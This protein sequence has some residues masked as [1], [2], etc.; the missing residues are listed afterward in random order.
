MQGH[1]S[2]VNVALLTNLQC[3]CRRLT[4]TYTMQGNLKNSL[5]ARHAPC[6][7]RLY[8]SKLSFLITTRVSPLRTLCSC[9]LLGTLLLELPLSM[10]EEVASVSIEDHEFTRLESEATGLVAC[11][12]RSR[13]YRLPGLLLRAERFERHVFGFH[14]RLVFGDR[15]HRGIRCESFSVCWLQSSP[16]RWVCW[17]KDLLYAG[18]HQ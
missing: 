17:G 10:R 4:Q 15:W 14:F 18:T 12:S 16:T 5:P 11:F 1:S 7:S 8:Q 9:I 6:H 3:R 2:T 13:P